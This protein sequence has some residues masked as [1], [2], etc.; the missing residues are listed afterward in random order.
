MLSALITFRSMQCELDRA[1]GIGTALIGS[2]AYSM[3]VDECPPV[4]LAKFVNFHSHLYNLVKMCRCGERLLVLM[5]T[6]K[7]SRT[8]IPRLGLQATIFSSFGS[9]FH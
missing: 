1:P 3:H 8:T 9:T 6:L 2:E 4:N 5:P 7:Y